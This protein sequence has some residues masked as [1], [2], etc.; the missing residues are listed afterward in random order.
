MA[1][2]GLGEKLLESRI[3]LAWDEAAG[4]LASHARPLKIRY[5]KLEV[6]VPSSVW[7]TQI[8]FVK[9][10]IVDRLNASAGKKVIGELVLLNTQKTN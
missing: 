3:L 10:E 6:A 8:S 4:P 7:R 9:Q 2:L 1:E 5:G